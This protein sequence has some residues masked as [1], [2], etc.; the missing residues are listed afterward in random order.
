[1]KSQTDRSKTIL[2]LYLDQ[3]DGDKI[4]LQPASSDTDS[5][6]SEPAVRPAMPDTH[7]GRELFEPGD[8][9]LYEKVLAQLAD[10]G[11]DPTVYGYASGIVGLRLFPNPN[12]FGKTD[13][14][15][16]ARDLWM[17]EIANNP[18]GD[19]YYTDSSINA[20]PNLVRPFRV[21]MSC[22]F[23]HIAPHP[24]NPPA[25]PEKPDWSNLSSTI[26]DQYWKP[27]ATFTNLK[28]ADSFLYQFLASQQ[29][30]TIDTSLVS[31]DHINNA[32]TITAIFD[33][34]ARLARAS[35]NPPE[36]QSASNLLI[37]GVEDP[38]SAANPRHTPRVLLDGSDSVGVF[39]ALSRVYLNIGT[40]SE[41][42]KRLHNT[43][44][45]FKPQRPFAVATALK[46]SVYW[47]TAEKYRIPYM[48][49][50]FRYVAKDTGE[51][52]TQPMRLADTG[53]G[54][55]RIEAERADASKGRGVFI[56]NCAVCHSSKQP[57]GFSLSFARD[58]ADK[59][60]LAPNASPALTLPMDFADWDNFK[61][62][63]AYGDY[64]KQISDLASQASDQSDPFI[65]DN[66]LSTDIRVP[67]T[68]VGTNSGRAVA[69]NAMRG[70]V[71]DNFSSETYKNL[72]AVGEVHF[73][74]PFSGKPVDAW[75][76]NDSYAPPAGGP[77]YYRP[78][79]LISL[80]ATAPFLHNNALGE[81]THDP[82]VVGRL[83][84]FDDGIDKILW[85]DKREASP[86][87][88]SM[89]TCA[90]RWRSPEATTVSSIERP[91]PASSTFRHASSTP[92]SPG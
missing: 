81:Y 74:N 42:W 4:K 37:P 35:A 48:A 83:K 82:S 88:A 62:S 40:Y 69:T 8:R 65:K 76:N 67:V 61:K 29:P 22:G 47:R 31:T 7:A 33:L 73:F 11:V 68:L 55:R 89:V 18:K 86:P 49:A 63:P 91:S 43:V 72:P 71:W 44:V 2:G 53:D 54:K 25:N 17:K 75:G 13:A 16:K 58:W 38:Q 80:W 57:A 56:Q 66:F 20:D 39:G 41:E 9:A 77:G 21:S 52:V 84:A 6:A 45:G 78:A 32:N 26:G 46:N 92:L 3:A 64:V 36:E 1:M 30:G 34:P 14:A 28:K 51:T 27:V 79:S 23:C 5:G 12:F 10:D 19:N 15:Q 24:L 59:Q 90:A 60:V 87:C 70:Q 85:P 50:F